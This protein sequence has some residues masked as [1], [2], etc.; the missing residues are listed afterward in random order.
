[1][2][3][4]INEIFSSI[5][6]EGI[7]LGEKQ[8]FVRFAGCNLKCSYCDT[9]F[10]NFREYDAQG[11]L[12][13]IESYGKNL[14]S[15]SLTGGEPLLQKDFLKEILACLKQRNYRTYLETN[16]ILPYG[17][18]E[19]I[20]NV[21]IVAMDIKLPSSSENAANSYWQEHRD[22]IQIARKKDMF[23]KA[24]ISIS[25]TEDDFVTMLDMLMGLD[26]CGILVL[27]PNSL[28]GLA[29]LEEKLAILKNLTA[30]YHLPVCIIPQVHKA[31][32]VK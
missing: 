3:G 12:A 28:D 1:M 25:T 23:I 7:F 5:Q 20:D 24:V 9:A 4:R 19:V 14:H 11:L 18:A 26:Y 27:Q 16:G 21:D 10:E 31:I 6:G 29:K 2:L 30:K 22:F 8:V 13:E 17:L 15:I 32:G